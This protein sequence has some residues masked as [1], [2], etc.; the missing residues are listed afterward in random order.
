MK[1]YLFIFKSAVMTNL[2]YVFNLV[3]HFFAFFVMIFIFMNLWN[4]MYDDPSELING[5][6]KNQMIWYVIIT[7]MMWFIVG[8]RKACQKIAGEVKAGS[9]AY[10]M[11]KPYNY[12]L[13]HLISHMGTMF[14][15]GIAYF[16]TDA[17]KIT[18]SKYLF[19][20]LINSFAPGRI[21]TC[22][23][24]GSFS[25]ANFKTISLSEEE[26]GEC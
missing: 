3:S 10:S 13:Y 14:I 21:R 8:G 9:I 17:V 6:T 4:Y 5:Y 11:N 15:K 12:V 16:E 26:N 19:I 2:Q 24:W 20:F 22:I 25:R 18:I 1:K 23:S 7:E